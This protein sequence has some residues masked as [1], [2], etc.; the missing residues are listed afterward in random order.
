MFGLINL[1]RSL[2][3]VLPFFLQKII[4]EG[5]RESIQKVQWV[6]EQGKCRKSQKMRNILFSRA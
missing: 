4:K 1:K 5:S 3:S 2:N 6:E